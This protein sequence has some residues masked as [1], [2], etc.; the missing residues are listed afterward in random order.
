MIRS[1]LASSFI[2]SPNVE[3]RSGGRSVDMI[4]LHYTGMESAEAALN[5]LC[6]PASGVSC[7]Y[8]VD[9]SGEISQLV[10]EEMRAW[11]AGVSSWGGDTDTNSRSVGIEI[12]NR[13]H[14]IGY[15]D[16]PDLQ[17]RAVVKL[18]RDIASRHDIPA[19][20]V[21]AHSDVAPGRKIDPGEKFNWAFLHSG[22]VGHWVAPAPIADGLAL[23]SSDRNAAVKE[24]QQMLRDYGYGLA[25]SGDYDRDTAAVV[26]AFQR[27]FRPARLDGAADRS[28]IETLRRLTAG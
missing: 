24:L 14:N 15:G 6:N 17:L 19:G 21:L 25:V 11:H 27:H 18:C 9:E 10:G 3:P 12:H 16:F 23:K 4:V 8:L 20:H 26:M 22:G 2:L 5:W 13:G 7:H 28:T 1:P